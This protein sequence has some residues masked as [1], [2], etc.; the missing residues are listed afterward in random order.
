MQAAH[1]RLNWCICD[2]AAIFAAVRDVAWNGRAVPSTSDWAPV[3]SARVSFQ[4]ASRS[5][6]GS[7]PGRLPVIYVL[8]KRVS[9]QLDN[10]GM[11]CRQGNAHRLLQ[12]GNNSAGT[13][14]GKANLRLCRLTLKLRGTKK[15]PALLF[16]VPCFRR[17]EIC[18]KF[19]T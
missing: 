1:N 15:A 5:E 6:T 10:P 7:D 2:Q 9:Q 3:V 16:A 19:S 17:E 12:R 18:R 13:E 4:D 11:R 8:S 14:P